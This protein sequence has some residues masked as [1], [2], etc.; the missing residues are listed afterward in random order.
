MKP[1]TFVFA[2]VMSAV[3]A[4]AATGAEVSAPPRQAL[5]VEH[6][7]VIADLVLLDADPLIDIRNTSKIR[8]VVANGRLYDLAALD[9]ILTGAEYHQT[10]K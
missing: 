1:T 9:G 7:T 8:A 4:N 6:V 10:K 5:I 2:A 3:L